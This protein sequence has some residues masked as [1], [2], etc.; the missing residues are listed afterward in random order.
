MTQTKFQIHSQRNDTMTPNWILTHPPPHNEKKGKEKLGS[1]KI[2]LTWQHL[3]S[4]QQHILQD[5]TRTWEMSIKINHVSWETS[6]PCTSS[7]FLILHGCNLY[8]EKSDEK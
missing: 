7:F 3:W 6:Q 2:K 1:L 4:L 5:Y 8:S